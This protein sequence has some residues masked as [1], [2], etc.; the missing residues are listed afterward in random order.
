MP[1]EVLPRRDAGK[2]ITKLD[3][4]TASLL[5]LYSRM[6]NSRRAAKYEQY[7]RELSNNKVALQ[8]LQSLKNACS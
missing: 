3:R 2:K 8:I 4:K 1:V 7:A 6:P 5:S